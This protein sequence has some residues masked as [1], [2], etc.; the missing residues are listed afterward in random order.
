[1]KC[2]EVFGEDRQTASPSVEQTLRDRYIAAIES[3][4]DGVD[5]SKMKQPAPQKVLGNYS[6]DFV[7][8]NG[9]TYICRICDE[10]KRK[11]GCVDSGLELLHRPKDGSLKRL[12]AELDQKC[13]FHLITE[14]AGGGPEFDPQIFQRFRLVP[15]H[16][17]DEWIFQMNLDS[18]DYR[19]TI[20]K[21]TG[22]YV[23]E[24]NLEDF[25]KAV[26]AGMLI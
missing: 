26:A 21:D 1:M 13:L 9:D 10:N 16:T 4:G 18:E 5:I 11:L 22:I 12:P 3:S 6:F 14:L 19:C 25:W 7:Q 24:K 15:E 8:P 2:L 20:R 23:I 17:P